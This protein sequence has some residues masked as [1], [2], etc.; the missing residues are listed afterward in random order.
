MVEY[1]QMCIGYSFTGLSKEKAIFICFGSE[2]DNGKTLLLHLLRRIAGDYGATIRV[3]SLMAKK[4]SN[5]VSSDLADLRGA[6]YV[7]TSETEPGQRLSQSTLKFLTQG[8]G[9]MRARRMREN[10]VVFPETHTIWLDC[11]T[12]PAMPNDVEDPALRRLI[13]IEFRAQISRDKMDRDL[14]EKLYEERS[15][16][17]GWIVEGAVKW[18]NSGQMLNHPPEI[19][20][21]RDRW[22]RADPFVRFIEERCDIEDG[23][24]IFARAMH[25]EFLVWWKTSG[26]GEPMNE[27]LFGTRMRKRFPAG[28]H[29]EDGWVYFGVGLRVSEPK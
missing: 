29:T 23:R 24:R 2:G 26:R 15:G 17:A 25:R 3:S 12:L 13:P 19:D 21:A 27:T 5:A 20:L 22:R 28:K 10:W 7:M 8:Q 1:L 16:I 4:D 6:R 9:V 11:N 18:F 14:G